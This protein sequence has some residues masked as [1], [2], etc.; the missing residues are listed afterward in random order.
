MENTGKASVLR[1]SLPPATR[2]RRIVLFPM[3]FQG[4]ITPMLQL[5]NILHTQGFKITIVHTEYNSPNHSNYPHF[6]FKSISDR[7]SEIVNAELDASYY[8]TYLNKS[9]KDSFTKCLSELLADEDDIPVAC[10]ITD[11]MFY[12]TQAVADE[13]KIPRL[14]LQPM[15]LGC[16]VASDILLSL[17]DENHLFTLPKE[18]H[19]TLAIK[20][21]PLKVKDVGKGIID[22]KGMGELVINTHNQMKASSGIIWN[23]FKELEKSALETICQDYRIPNFTFGP[24]H[25][26]FTTSS[27]S[28]IEQ[29]RNI[30]SWL[31]TQAPKS[32]IYVSFGSVARITESEFQEVAHGLANTGLP[33]LW[34]VRPGVVYGSE[35]LELLPEK[36]LESV[37]DKGRIV[38]WSPQPEVLAHPAT[39]CFWTHNGWN[40]TLESVCEGVPMAARKGAV[41]CL[42]SDSVWHFTQS[43]ADSLNLP[44]I[45]LRT[46]SMSCTLVYA[47]LPFIQEKGNIQGLPPMTQKDILKIYSGGFEEGKLEL[48]S[49]MIKETKAAS[50]VIYNTFKELEEPA[51]LTT[52]QDFHNPFPIGPF[53]KYFPASSSSLL[54][55]DRSSISWLDLQPVN[56]VLYVSFGSI[57]QMDEAEFTN[58][59]CGLASSNQR[60]LW[61]VRPGSVLGS[62]WL[63]SLPNGFM[64]KVGE[65]GCI[66]KWAPQQ[67]VLAHQAIGGFWTHCGWNSTLE[68]ICEGV[69]MICSPCSYDQPV[70][71]RY[72]ADVW[73]IG[74][75]LEN[76]IEVQE[77]EK[78]IKR[79]M[80][81]KEGDEMRER[82]KSLQEKANLSLQ[83]DGSAT[84]AL[85]NL[86]DYILSL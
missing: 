15:S 25:K 69:P 54:E 19:E 22:P 49:S 63:E 26:Y 34:V 33:F 17:S 3:P 84:Q 57:A 72:V 56:S 74:V 28:L 23:T 58:M 39:G 80:V 43:V 5:A 52:S 8:L 12:F 35:W 47:A 36:Y 7:F 16:V 14:V 46:S 20:L 71:A 41:A 78:A 40:S 38:K 64:D 45:V 1:P 51:F 37:G 50:G 79:V 62:E 53:H 44:R 18:D 29:D 24:F 59:A 9:C 2:R 32:V 21:K 60:F 48:I 61:V 75:I 10:L 81:E 66:V 76:G 68:S 83:K 65:R 70:H 77:I 31:D 85:E 55:Q 73:R 4:H 13:L 30:L 6:T 67:E 42:I 82:S 27:S 86:V 11:A